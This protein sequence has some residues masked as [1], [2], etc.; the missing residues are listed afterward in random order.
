MALLSRRIVIAGSGALLFAGGGVYFG[1]MRGPEIL[2][3]AQV[4][5]V[6]GVAIRGTD[7]V[8]YFTEGKP[9]AGKKEFSHEWAGATW[10]F[11]N[12]DN[13]DT[14]LAEPD[15]Y[16]PQYGGFC[17]WAVAAKGRLYSTQPGNW[18]IVGG[19]LYLNYSDGIQEIWDKD[20]QKFI[21][22]GDKRWPQITGGLV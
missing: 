7:P 9:V 4:F 1:L 20:R 5:A 10:Y 17:A 11:A 6:D 15:R 19:K 21:M 18:S 16:A 13:R 22:D 3:P 2:E 12:A 14:F 8:A